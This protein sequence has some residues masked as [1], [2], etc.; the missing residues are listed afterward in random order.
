MKKLFLSIALIWATTIAFAQ[1]VDLATA[2]KA[3]DNYR[4][5]I[6]PQQTSTVSSSYTQTKDGMAV[7]YIF[8]YTE[9]GFVIVSAQRSS[10][11]I[12]AY[13]FENPF[14][15]KMSNPA[16]KSWMKCYETEIYL[17]AQP[18]A[19]TQASTIKMWEDLENNRLVQQKSTSGVEPL[20]TSKWGQ[21]AYYNNFCPI[22]NDASGYHTPTGCVATAMAQVMYYHRH[23]ET[24]VGNSSYTSPYGKLSADYANTHYDFNSMEDVSSRFS[25]AL[26][27]LM[28]HVG[29]SLEMTYGPDGSSSSG[30]KIP[31][32]MKKYFNYSSTI[33][34]AERNNYDTAGWKNLI[35]TQL[36][37]RLPVTYSGSP[38][39]GGAGHAWVCDGYDSRD[40]FHMN[41][42]WDGSADGYYDIDELI[43]IKISASQYADLDINHN[44][45]YNIIPKKIS[46]P[47][48][49]TLTATC[50]SF[51]DGSG[52]LD[53]ANNDSR[54]WL[55]QP[56][57]A[58]SITL[59]CSR[60]LTDTNDVVTI[61][62]GNSV[63]DSILATYSGK[64]VTGTTITI[65]KPSVL[66]TFTTD[67]D[68]TDD[69]FVFS[70]NSTYNNPNFCNTTQSINNTNKITDATGSV[71]NG[72]GNENYA[73]DNTCWWRI[74]PQNAEEVWISFDKFDLGEGDVLSVFSYPTFNPSVMLGNTYLAATYT[75]E[76]PPALNKEIVLNNK[77]IYLKF[78]TD[79]NNSGTGWSFNYGNNVSVE[80]A[81]SGF[82]SCNVYPNP[83]K[84]AIY[85]DI[86][87]KEVENKE[88]FI[89]LTDVTGREL[90]STKTNVQSELNHQINTDALANG[91]YFLS[92]QTNEGI[93]CKKVQVNK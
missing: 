44:I 39:K 56:T 22:D 35:K 12:I 83:A 6:R 92:V 31:N 3:A 46:F 45:T 82:A 55:I 23:P 73:N 90:Y 1:T 41:W 16:L 13:S 88:V 25:G 50:G 14:D 71:N 2:Q 33:Q 63:N 7:Y 8:N 84:E 17:A 78:Q 10:K 68:L 49:D 52:Y 32:A 30:S 64:Y 70:Y 86:K 21:A 72:S 24:G 5:H 74:E 91:C 53:Y 26:A 75:K 85:L 28:S 43:N 48:H 15:F 62:N 89:R 40:Y 69:G 65:N 57:N 60:F 37:Q 4:N 79:N 54:S 9:G 19:K 77:C 42:G 11:P 59:T 67:N 76:D 29:I 18:E 81:Q 66:I 20:L 38:S 93:I 36:D 87:F 47:Q 51:S 27:T 61:Y 80:E 34:F 58:E